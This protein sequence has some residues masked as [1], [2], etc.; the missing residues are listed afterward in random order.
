VQIEPA[1]LDCRLDAGAELRAASL[2][3][4]EEGVVNLLDMDS[5]VL[6]CPNARSQLNELAG[7][8]LWIWQKGV[9]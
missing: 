3:R 5:A 4:V 8:S 7:G 2:E 1:A 6:Y 9:Q